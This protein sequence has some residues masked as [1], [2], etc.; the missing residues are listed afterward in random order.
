MVFGR[1]TYNFEQAAEGALAA[2]AAIRVEDARGAMAAALELTRDAQRRARMGRNA[3]DFVAGHRGAT[4]RLAQWLE[5]ARASR[6]RG[7]G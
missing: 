4:A 5:A 3:R 7:P 1:H 6:A 2:Q